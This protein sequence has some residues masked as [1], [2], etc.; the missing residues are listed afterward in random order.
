ML[1]S[2]RLALG[3]GGLT[4]GGDWGGV[5]CVGVVGVSGVVGFGVGGFD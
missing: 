3:V 2:P 1:M 5:V 4:S